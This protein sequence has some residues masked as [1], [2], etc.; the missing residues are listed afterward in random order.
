MTAT[1]PPG[2]KRRGQDETPVQDALLSFAPD[3]AAGPQGLRPQH[4]KGRSSRGTWTRQCRPST[5]WRAPRPR[6]TSQTPSFLGSPRQ[7]HTHGIEEEG[8]EDTRRLTAKALLSTVTL[9]MTRYLQPSQLG[10]GTAGGCETIVQ[11]IR[12]WLQCRS[13]DDGRCFF[14]HGLGEHV[15]PDRQVVLPARSLA[16]CA[17]IDQVQRLVL[18]EGRLRVVQTEEHAEQKSSSTAEPPNPLLPTPPPLHPCRNNL[19]IKNLLDTPA[20]DSNTLEH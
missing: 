3:S 9:E 16:G 20:Q 18:L 19:I 8:R 14:D 7:C 17:R 2:R 10:F 13:N 4:I 12:R 15:Q 5:A 11:A 1:L 6:A